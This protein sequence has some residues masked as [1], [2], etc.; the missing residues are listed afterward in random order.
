MKWKITD[1]ILRKL[2]GF[3]EPEK[4]FE[5]VMKEMTGVRRF[6]EDREK[7]LAQLLANSR[8][9]QE[10]VGIKN[11][12]DCVLRKASA[13]ASALASEVGVGALDS[14]Q[15]LAVRFGIGKADRRWWDVYYDF[16]LFYMRMADREAYEFLGK[17]R[18]IFMDCLCSEVV[19]IC[20]GHFDDDKKAAQFEVSFFENFNLFQRQFASYQT[21]KVAS[22]PL[23]EQVEYRFSERIARRLDL[24]LDFRL[25][26]GSTCTAGYILLNIPGLLTGKPRTKGKGL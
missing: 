3:R 18:G 2:S 14:L 17:R 15:S 19:R 13:L 20:R 1:V 24:G 21:Y 9:W 25:L 7:V 8:Q 6:M 16:L 12:D 10:F 5:Q 26:V 23:G 11:S 22:V 4:P